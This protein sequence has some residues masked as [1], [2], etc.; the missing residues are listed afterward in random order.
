M[1]TFFR[2]SCIKNSGYLQADDAALYI[3]LKGSDPNLKI[4]FLVR[5]LNAGE[6]YK[7]CKEE[8]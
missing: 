5:T 7:E 8:D 1:P 6:I 2:S 4:R 3:K